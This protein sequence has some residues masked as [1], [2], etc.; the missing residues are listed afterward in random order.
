MAVIGINYNYNGEDVAEVVTYKSVYL[1]TSD[2]ELEFNSGD[3]VKDWFDAKLEYTKIMDVD[4]YLSQ[5]STCDHFIMDGANYD[6]AY[7]HINGNQPILK[8]INTDDPHYLFT[9]QDVYENGW[10]F[11]VPIGSKPTWEELKELCKYKK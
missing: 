2:K 6:S 3:F 1:H 7:L 8:Y 11:F 5:S 10:E 4:P 9:Q